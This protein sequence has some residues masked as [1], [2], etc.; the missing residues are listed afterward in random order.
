MTECRPLLCNVH[1]NR[2]YSDTTPTKRLTKADLFIDPSA[3]G[4]GYG[5][6][7]IEA[8]AEE[9]REQ[10]CLRLQWSTK[11]ENPA[12]KLYDQMAKCEFVEYRMQL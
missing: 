1:P 2:A 12:R 8:V 10:G 9:A 3:R 4:K 11:H 6:D 5:R 7:M